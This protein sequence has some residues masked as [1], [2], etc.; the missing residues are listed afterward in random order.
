MQSWCQNRWHH[1]RI[2]MTLCVLLHDVTKVTHLIN[3][4]RHNIASFKPHWLS[5]RHINTVFCT[6]MEPW[7][8]VDVASS[9]SLIF[10]HVNMVDCTRAQFTYVVDCTRAQLR[11]VKHCFPGLHEKWMYVAQ[12]S[13]HKNTRIHTFKT[14]VGNHL[15]S[16][17]KCV[18]NTKVYTMWL[19]ISTTKLGDCGSQQQNLDTLH[20]KA[21]LPGTEDTMI[22]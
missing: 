1:S 10:L 12:I 17:L 14:T 2:I 20:V 18:Y 16:N 5:R 11:Y 7:S 4:W 8:T 21:Y 6:Y 15:T 19:W 3:R 13:R 9:W 22:H